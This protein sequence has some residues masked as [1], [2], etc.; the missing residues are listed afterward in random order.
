M[1]SL[2]V[3][4]MTFATVLS[5]RLEERA[6]D[7]QG[8][9]AAEYLGIIVL[10]GLILSAIFLLDLDGDIS[11]KIGSVIDGITGQT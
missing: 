5:Q 8:Q 7:E 6:R 3:Q 1:T 9:T 2:Y 11:V 4:V 10:V